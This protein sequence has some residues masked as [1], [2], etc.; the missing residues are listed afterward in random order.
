VDEEG[1]MLIFG[2]NGNSSGIVYELDL[3]E[4][5]WS[6]NNNVSYTRYGHSANVIGDS[7]YL[8]AGYYLGGRNDICSSF[9]F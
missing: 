7:V 3:T 4:M 2:G 8:F 1:I 6:K 9:C 5:R